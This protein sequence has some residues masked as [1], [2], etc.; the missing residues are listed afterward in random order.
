MVY[1]WPQA[2]VL[3]T[4]MVVL[5]RSSP[6]I[7]AGVRMVNGA[8]DGSVEG[9]RQHC[10]GILYS[11]VLRSLVACCSLHIS[12]CSLPHRGRAGNAQGVQPDRPT[13]IRS[14]IEITIMTI[15]LSLF[16]LVSMPS[17]RRHPRSD[18]RSEVVSMA[19]LWYAS[20]PSR[21]RKP[22]P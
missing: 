17:I 7:S 18:L 4:L 20:K 22:R 14:T 5:E 10:D 13:V 3:R 15:I 1:Q 6:P 2:R 21:T 11:K 19:N 16:M 8:L 9:R 12:F